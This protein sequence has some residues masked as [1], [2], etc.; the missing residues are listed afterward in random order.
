MKNLSTVDNYITFKY[1]AT[2]YLRTIKKKLKK[3]KKIDKLVSHFAPFSG[4]IYGGIKNKE[5]KMKKQNLVIGL[6]LVFFLVVQVLFSIPVT[7]LDQETQE[8]IY[9][10]SKDI[11]DVPIVTEDYVEENGGEIY[12]QTPDYV[13]IIVDDKIIILKK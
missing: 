7:E 5:V 6:I 2:I 1:L 3:I 8:I 10:Y 12:D 13:I 11:K 4:Y 9:S